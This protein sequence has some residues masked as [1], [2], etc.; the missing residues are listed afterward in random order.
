[1][2]KK[3]TL[4]LLVLFLYSCAPVS[5]TP[6]LLPPSTLPPRSPSPPE[7]ET[8]SLA[9]GYGIRG[10]WYSLYFTDPDD[11]DAQ[12]KRGG[13]DSL[14]AAA[15]DDAEL[16]VDVAA[17]S[18]S[19]WSI[20]DALIRAHR[21]GVKVRV[22]MESDNLD[23]SVPQ[24]L[25]EAGI[26]IVGDFREGL[27]HDKFVVIDSSE[28][29]TGSMN[30]TVSG[31]YRD[32]NNL[33]CIR[34]VKAAEDYE[35]EFEEMFVEN[36]FGEDTAAETPNPVFS[37]DGTR[38]EV[39]FSP[40]DGV[41]A[42]LVSL[43]EEAQEN[44]FFLA[45]SFTSDALSETLMRLSERGVTVAGVMDTQQAHSN[46]GTEYDI[47]LQN[48]I[49]ALLDGNEDG[50]MHHKVFIIDEQIVVTGSYNFTRSAETR[51]DENVLVIHD[52]DIARFYLEE[53]RR[54]YDEG[55]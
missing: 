7:T 54:I 51:N 10:T 45:Y 36:L 2:S 14:L 17:Y 5:P 34:S 23:R 49:D 3:H 32:N 39:Y 38:L 6:I 40:D 1:M 48:G 47:F 18:M 24:D 13:P 16:S 41:E 8:L 20:R 33:I 19:L 37:V 31:S 42:R 29:W 52:P 11:P 55:K 25:I 21:R 30:F 46:I 22:V 53:F 35:K 27:M 12:T 4:F 9:S 26:P 15:I 43:L 50:L 44:V 28:V